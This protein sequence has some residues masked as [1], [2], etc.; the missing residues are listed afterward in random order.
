[1]TY[2]HQRIAL[3]SS[4]SKKIKKNNFQKDHQFKRMLGK[5]VDYR[6]SKLYLNLQSISRTFKTLIQTEE[7]IIMVVDRK[8]RIQDHMS[9]KI[10]L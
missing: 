5:M 4:C 6:G 1:M 3:T 7:L 8:Y 9:L 10:I 2:T